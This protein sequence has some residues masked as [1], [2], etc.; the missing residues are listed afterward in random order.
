M[1]KSA[2]TILD[3]SLSADSYLN[4]LYMPTTFPRSEKSRRSVSPNGNSRYGP[5]FEDGPR[6]N[7]DS[8]R[9]AECVSYLRDVS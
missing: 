2:P 1:A 6:S 5:D 9:Y 8:E 4:V 3:D 7:L